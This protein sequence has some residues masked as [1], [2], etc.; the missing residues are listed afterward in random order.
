MEH[1]PFD[2]QPCSGNAYNLQ[3]EGDVGEQASVRSSTSSETRR[4]QKK[5]VGGKGTGARGATTMANV[6]KSS[7]TQKIPIQINER[8]LPEGENR[9]TFNSYIGVAVR[10]HVSITYKKWADVPMECKDKLWDDLNVINICITVSL[11]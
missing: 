8:G 5:G 10:A 7:L 11:N 2:V 4:S 1:D 6:I 3:P 9:A